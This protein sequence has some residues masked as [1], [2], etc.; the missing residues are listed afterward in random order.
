[1]NLHLVVLTPGKNQGRAIPVATSPFCVGRSPQ[2]H[3]RPAS[4]VIS[5]LHCSLLARSGRAFVRDHDSTS[6]TF[7]NDRRVQGEVE[8]HD[9]DR[10]QVGPLALLVRLQ[11]G[12]PLNRPTPLPATRQAD[13]GAPGEDAAAALLLALPDEDRPA[14][15][16]GFGR[17]G[18]DAGV[19]VPTPAQAGAAPGGKP[20]ATA[21]SAAAAAKALMHEYRRRER[22]R[23]R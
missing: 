8:L 14:G 18:G 1:M 23:P 9:Y 20:V 4:P 6:G 15:D 10:V 17:E 16:S 19:V 7:V 2:C 21:E 13:A 5:L 12:T 11:A 22:R 3:L